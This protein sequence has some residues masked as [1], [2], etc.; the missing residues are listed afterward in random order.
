MC[1]QNKLLS[2]GQMRKPRRDAASSIARNL[3]FRA[4]RIE[5][6]DP[7]TV[8]ELNSISS[9]TSVAR[10]HGASQL[11]MAAMC[12]NFVNDEEIVAAGVRFDVINHVPETRW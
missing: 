1:V 3:G 4:I 10:A 6:T 2:T 7:A 8:Q 11:G 5:E 12:K 9:N